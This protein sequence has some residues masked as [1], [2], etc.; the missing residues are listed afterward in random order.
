MSS[1]AMD[2]LQSFWWPLMQQRSQQ[3]QAGRQPA[4][5]IDIG[6]SALQVKLRGGTAVV[7]HL[8]TYLQPEYLSGLR[9]P[10]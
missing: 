4:H 1:F 9:A 6:G 2:I 8:S 10:A 3:Q 7:P 5:L